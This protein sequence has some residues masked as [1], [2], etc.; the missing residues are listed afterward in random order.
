MAAAHL[1]DGVDFCNFFTVAAAAVMYSDNRLSLSSY[2][3]FSLVHFFN[4]IPFATVNLY[5]SIIA[6]VT[7]AALADT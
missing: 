2:V 6:P 7:S 5:G 4:W 3:V 1:L